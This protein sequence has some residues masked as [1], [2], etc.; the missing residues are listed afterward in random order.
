[1]RLTVLE[2]SACAVGAPV[3]YRIAVHL[4]IG[5]LTGLR[6]R[7]FRITGGGSESREVT[8]LVDRQ[9]IIFSPPAGGRLEVHAR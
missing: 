1:M 2:Y 6:T 4:A 3:P 9:G 5:P 8:A 7:S